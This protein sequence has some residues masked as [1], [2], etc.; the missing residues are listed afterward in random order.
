VLVLQN[1]LLDYMKRN[2]QFHLINHQARIGDSLHFHAYGLYQAE[3]GG[4]SLQLEERASTDVE[5][6]K[7]SLGLQAE[8]RIELMAILNA[9]ERKITAQTRFLPAALR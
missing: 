3:S 5:G 7:T 9:L 4:H 6:L 1:R 2:F 8:Q